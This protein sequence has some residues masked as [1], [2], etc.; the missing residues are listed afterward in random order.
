MQVGIHYDGKFYEFV[1]WTGVVKWE[2]ALW[3]R[4]HIAAESETHMVGTSFDV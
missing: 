4:W 2:V 1:P 3:G